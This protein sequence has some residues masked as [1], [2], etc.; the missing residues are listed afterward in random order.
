[1]SS[2]YTDDDMYLSMYEEEVV[3]IIPEC[4]SCCAPLGACT[5]EAV[6]CDVTSNLGN[7]STCTCCEAAGA[8]QGETSDEESPSEENVEA[9]G[10]GT[11]EG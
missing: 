9:V 6:T 3:E 1:M 7:V 8:A 10:N 2:K 5:G 4:T 11:S